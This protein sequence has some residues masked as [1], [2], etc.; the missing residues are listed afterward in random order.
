MYKPNDITLP[1]LMEN[2]VFNEWSPILE[3]F[4]G[5]E[6]KPERMSWM[7]KLAHFQHLNEN[8]TF[9]SASVATLQNTPG[10][11]NPSFG[12]TLGTQNDFVTGARGSGDKW[13]SP[14]SV[15]LQVAAK[16]VGFDCVNVIPISSPNGMI[17]YVDY[18][19]ADGVLDGTGNDN[20]LLFKIPVSS[21]YASKGDNF[22]ATANTSITSGDEVGGLTNSARLEYV[23]RARIDGYPIFKLLGTGTIDANAVTDT[24][25]LKIA[26]VFDGTATLVAAS[27]ASTID[28][29]GNIY[30]VT[31]S[32][33]YVYAFEDQ[34]YGFGNGEGGQDSV[35]YEGNWVDGQT[36]LEGARRGEGEADA[37]KNM[38][39]KIASK[40]VETRTFK[41]AITVTQEQLQDMKRQ[42]GFDLVAKAENALVN[43]ASQNINKN[44]LARMFALGWSNHYKAN[45]SEGIKLNLNLD[46]SSSSDTTVSYV[47]NGGTSRSI[48]LPAYQTYAAASASFENQETLQR[49]IYSRINAASDIINNRGRRGPATGVVTNAQI[50]SALKNVANYAHSPVP[51]TLQQGGNLYPAGKIGDME[52]YVDPNMKY[53]DNR[54]CVFR[55]GDDDEP[56]L[57]FLPYLLG[58]SVQTISPETMA[59]KIAVTSRFALTEYGQHPETQYFTFH[60]NVPGGGII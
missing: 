31:G 52:L 45:A 12:S 53:D 34:V 40:N 13:I 3:N 50:A 22:I 51:N 4:T 28:T 33:S 7:T 47:D 48:T 18:I 8:S 23:G 19:Y 49:R 6:V 57:K 41:V 60:V 44:I 56:G 43:E 27:D 36:T 20:P 10:Y 1:K 25:D 5:E 32:A 9:D 37:W 29:T 54:V 2:E 16:T 24:T 39:V 42:H 11:G 55:K 58:E 38:G 46:P 17:Y 59:P 35:Q 14:F 21:L 26:D 15:A 30:Q